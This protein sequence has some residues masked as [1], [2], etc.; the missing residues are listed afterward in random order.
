MKE[1]LPD[2]LVTACSGPVATTADS[3]VELDRGTWLF[4]LGG[5]AVSG[6]THGSPQFPFCLLGPGR[7][8]L[9]DTLFSPGQAPSF[10]PAQVG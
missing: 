8:I 3:G 7:W 6:V 1:T 10:I 2:V 5:E 9:S 4:Y